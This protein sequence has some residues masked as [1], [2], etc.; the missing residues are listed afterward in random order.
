MED[1]GN[2]AENAPQWAIT[3][4]NSMEEK[5]EDLLNICSDKSDQTQKLKKEIFD[6]KNEN[7]QLKQRLLRLEA[8]QARDCLV[9]TG[10]E[11]KP[12]E[13][14]NSKMENLL[15]TVFNLKTNFINCIRKGKKVAGA[16][17]S[18]PVQVRFF[19]T[20]DRNHV[21]GKRSCCRVYSLQMF[22]EFTPDQEKSRRE[23][24]PVFHKAVEMYKKKE[25]KEKPTLNK[26]KLSIEGVTYTSKNMKMIPGKFNKEFHKSNDEVFA[27][28]GKGC[29]LSNFHPSSFDVNDTT[30][31]CMEQYYQA[32]KML[33]CGTRMAYEQIM[34]SENPYNMK[35]IAKKF[36]DTQEW[37]AK[38][39]GVML[40]GLRAKFSEGD[41]LKFLTDTEDKV[42]AECN[43]HDG[44]WGNNLS[45][46]SIDKFNPDNWI[47]KNKLGELLMRVRDERRGPR[48]RRT[49][50]AVAD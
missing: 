33:V 43:P 27:F 2:N 19:R 15:E 45:I 49:P 34:M 25:I 10:I 48:G 37:N 50:P 8:T 1:T 21:W 11:E 39:I 22:E 23:L 5:F 16:S 29:P 35:A 4:K 12:D 42:V 18:R 14:L 31:N 46:N 3:L 36:K 32:Q 40:E 6:L 9:F 47:G 24:L 13:R 41:I 26:D 30:Y 17:G 28:F 20:E 7:D 38:R 44:F